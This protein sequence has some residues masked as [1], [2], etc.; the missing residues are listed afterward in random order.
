[1]FIKLC[2]YLMQRSH[3]ECGSV[4][5]LWRLFHVVVLVTSSADSIRTHFQAEVEMFLPGNECPVFWHIAA[6]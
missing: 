4:M 1:M 3:L 6:A 5:D 2:V